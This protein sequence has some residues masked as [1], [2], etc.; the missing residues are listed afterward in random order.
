MNT[1]YD[2]L[3]A[4]KNE[5]KKIASLCDRD[6]KDIE[7]IAV[8]K[9]KSVAQITE[10]IKAGQVSFGE[11]YV[12]E[13]IEKIKHFKQNMPEIPLTWHF[14]GPLQSNKSKLVAQYFDWMHTIDRFKIA[15]RLSEQR[16]PDMPKLNV[17]IQI[18]ISQESSKSGVTPEEAADLVNQIITLPNLKLRG[19]M[20]IPEIENDFKKQLSVFTQMKQ[21]LKVLQ[22]NYPFM[23][24]LSMGMS[25]DI[26]AAIVAGSTMV[27]IGRAIFGERQYL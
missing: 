12:Q 18:N 22:V 3:L 20:A 1:V 4:I 25:N 26:K 23:D 10:A 13:G 27:R 11:N 8:S 2:N 7:L 24:T 14:I 17:L 9:T 16:P 21:L 19:L 15:Q 6:P 5:I